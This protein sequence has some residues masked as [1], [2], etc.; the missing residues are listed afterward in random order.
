MSISSS[1]SMEPVS[2]VTAPPSLQ[3]AEPIS[4]VGSSSSAPGDCS[5]ASGAGEG[6][7]PNFLLGSFSPIR[8]MELYPPRA[9]VVGKS[10]AN[11]FLW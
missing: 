6:E 2:T 9:K 4:V 10:V 1:P 7:A 8:N 5:E 11:A 3:P